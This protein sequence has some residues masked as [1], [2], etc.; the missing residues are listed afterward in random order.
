MPRPRNTRPSPRNRRRKTKTRAKKKDPIMVDGQRPRPMY[1]DYKDVELLSK[2]VNRHG[3]IVSRR[4]SGCS[5]VSQ[6]A[7][8]EAIKRAR[9]MALMP[10]VGD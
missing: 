9:F 7:V 8:T 6:H 2:L 1:I 3:R 5:A 4:K 10:Y